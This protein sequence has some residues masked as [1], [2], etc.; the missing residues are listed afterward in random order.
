MKLKNNKP[1]RCL[2]VASTF[3]K[4]LNEIFVLGLVTNQAS[5]LSQCS[6]TNL[7]ITKDLKLVTCY[8]IP[9][10]NSDFSSNQLLEALNNSKHVLRKILS[11]K[12]TLKY[13]PEIRFI[14]DSSFEQLMKVNSL[15]DAISD[16]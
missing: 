14:Y 11:D 1:Y 9:C 2:R 12:V 13:M 3:Q 10:V 15:I 5:L 4:A 6:I 7:T 8:F 16:K